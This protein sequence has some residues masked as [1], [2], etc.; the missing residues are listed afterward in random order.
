MPG[1][2]GSYA[3]RGMDSWARRATSNEGHRAGRL[4]SVR[5]WLTGVVAARRS[6][7]RCRTRA[8]HGESG[9]GPA[10]DVVVDGELPV[11]GAGVD[12][13]TAGGGAGPAHPDVQDDGRAVALDV[14]LV[15]RV[16]V[17]VEVSAGD[18]GVAVGIGADLVDVGTSLGEQRGSLVRGDV[19]GGPG[20]TV[21]V[22]PQRTHAAGPVGG[23][24]AGAVR[25]FVRGGGHTLDDRDRDTDAAAE[26]RDPDGEQDPGPPAATRTRAWGRL[27]WRN[28][29]GHID[30]R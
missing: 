25:A 6:G 4:G 19:F 3:S 20:F 7:S 12:P 15:R 9:D 11:R 29:L 8:R 1:P 23:G 2:A 27:G 10:G 22:P 17:R 26:Y 28:G 21:G 14:D 30:R 24:A 13:Q 16:G 5:G 18:L